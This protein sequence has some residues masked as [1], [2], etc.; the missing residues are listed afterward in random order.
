MPKE[1][2]TTRLE[3]LIKEAKNHPLIAIILFIGIAVIGIS[4]FAGSIKSLGEILGLLTNGESKNSEL[5]Q[6]RGLSGGRTK[7]DD[8][9]KPS[10]KGP[11]DRDATARYLDKYPEGHYVFATSKYAIIPTNPNVTQRFTLDWGES[12]VEK[13]GG[14]FI[15]ITLR[16]FEYL[17]KHIEIQNLH[18]VLDNSPGAVAEGMYFDGISLCVELVESNV[19]ATTYVIGLRPGVPS[20]EQKVI[21]PDAMPIL[22]RIGVAIVP[23]VNTNSKSYISIQNFLI[24]SAWQASAPK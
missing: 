4:Q 16:K 11:L 1:Q 22:S 14:S 7:T 20:T 3:G 8:L 24:T 9:S 21:R 2:N 18:V 6:T 15:H 13:L 17:P 5:S 19:E 23:G 10:S 12:K